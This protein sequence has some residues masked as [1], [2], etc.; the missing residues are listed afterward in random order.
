MDEGVGVALIGT[1]MWGR[2]LA[3]A[4]ART[5]HLQIV[6]SYSRTAEKRDAFA[7]EFG[8]ESSVSLETA[9]SHPRVQGVLLVT[10]NHLHARG[11]IACVEH[12]KHVFVEKPIADALEDGQRMQ[13]ACAEAG[14]TLLVG[15]AFRRLGAARR[16]KTLLDQGVLGQVVLVEA[17]FSLPGTLTPDKWRYYRKTCPGGLLMQLGIHHADTLQYWLGP[18]RRAQGAFARLATTAEIDDVGLAQ[19]EFESGA[20]GTLSSSYVSP[21]SF[22]LHLYGTEANLNYETD[23]SIWPRAEEMDAATTLTLQTKSGRQRVAFASGD[24]L[25]EE[26]AEFARCVRGEATPETGPAE[27]LAAL[28]VIRQAINTHDRFVLEKVP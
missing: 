9:I 16:V 15:H 5:P 12:G 23:M 21:K 1:G 20:L 10:P 7:A 13:A 8:C 17:N 27:A 3:A 24:M 6:T 26:L 18:V 19:L 11:T 14:L 25:V 28:R 4:V 22:Y 2:R